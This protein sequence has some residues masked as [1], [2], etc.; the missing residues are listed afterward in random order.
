MHLAAR[1]PRLDLGLEP[2]RRA[3]E[4]RAGPGPRPGP[5]VDARARRGPRR[6]WRRTPIVVGELRPHWHWSS[7][8]FNTDA[9][10]PERSR[11]AGGADDGALRHRS[12][13]LP[14]HPGHPWPNIDLDFGAALAA[15]AIE[16]IARLASG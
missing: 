14:R 12:P 4:P 16:T 2:R 8:V 6:R 3:L 5:I 15:I 13:R 11:P 1:A 10:V 7:T 9:P